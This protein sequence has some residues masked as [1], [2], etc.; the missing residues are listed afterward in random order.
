VF[1]VASQFAQP[2][3]AIG[4]AAGALSAGGAMV[5]VAGLWLPFGPGAR[6]RRAF[7]RA[8]RRFQ[9]GAWQEALV[10]VREQQQN[11]RLPLAWAGRLRNL[12]GECLRL[13]GEQAI[14]EQRFEEG[15]EHWLGSARLLGLEEGEA[16]SRVLEAMLDN[17][18]RL[19][20]GNAAADIEAAIQLAERV[21]ALQ[22][23]CAEAAFWQGLCFVR[24]ER[25]DLALQALRAAHDT[26][27]DG[28]FDPAFYLGTFL[29]R[30]GS[31]REAV[32]YLSEANRLAP[33]APVA[34]WQLGAAILAANG[35]SQVAARALQKARERLSALRKNENS[36]KR[37]WLDS[38]PEGKSYVR[39]LSLKYT[40]ACPLLGNHV[41]IMLREVQLS[42]GQAY[43]RHG[44]FPEAVQQYTSVLQES[45]PTVPV[46]R[47]LGQA[48]ARLER[49]EEAY[50]HLRAAY[51]REGT[52]N[53][54]TAG[55]LALC[56]AKG[57]PTAAEDRVKNVQWAL[58][59]ISQFEVRDDGEWAEL[60]NAIHAEA[61]GLDLP[62]AADDQVRLCEALASVAA[63]DCAAAAAYEH[64]AATFP[65]RVRAEYAWLHCRAVQ[66]QRCGGAHELDLFARTFQDEAPARAF[67]AERHWDFEDMEYAYLE[68]SAARRPGSFPE[69]IAPEYPARGETLLLGRS[70]RLE[71]TADNAGAL[72]SAEVLLLLAP[73]SAAA[74]DRLAQLHFRQG[75]LERSLAL[76]ADWH[77]LEADK[78]LPLIRLAVVEHARGNR[79]G[80]T[81]AIE[82]ALERAQ[83]KARA[84]A[85]FLGAR[86]GLADLLRDQT[87]EPNAA[88]TQGQKV[89]HW[90]SVCLE[91]DPEHKDAL[92]C[93]A[94]C[95]ALRGDR[96]NLADL[97]QRL[98]QSGNTDA[99]FQFMAACSHLAA[100]ATTNAVEAS[101]H[102]ESLDAT[103]APETAYL[104]GLSHARAGE[105]AAAAN[106]FAKVAQVVNSPSRQHAQARLGLMRFGQGDYETAI[107]C[108]QTVD[109]ARRAAWGLEEPLR[110]TVFLS[111]LQAFQANEPGRAAQRLREAGRLGY[112]DQSLGGLLMLAL[113][114][115]GQRLLR[116]SNKLSEA[117]GD[118]LEAAA[119]LF[120]QALNAGS[121]QPETAYLLALA[122][123]RQGKW[124]EARSAFRKI[125]QP[126]PNVHLQ[127]GILSLREGQLAQAEQELSAA[128]DLE[129]QSYALGWNLLRTRLSLGQTDG[130]VPL[131]T[132]L[133]E[134]AAN[135]HDQRLFKQLQ[136]LMPGA[137]ADSQAASI[138]AE[139]NGV[140]EERLLDLL[141][142]LG[143][144]DL[145][146][147]LLQNWTAA[148]T[149]AQEA[150]FAA[151]L[152]KGKRL[153]ERCDWHGAEQLLSPLKE[154]EASP[155]MQRLLLNFLGCCCCLSQDFE[156][157]LWHFQA[158]LRLDKNDPCVQQNLALV[159]EW[160]GKHAEA[161]PSWNSY[162]ENLPRRASA[163]SLPVDYRDRLAFEG[164]SRLATLYADKEQWPAALEF[165]QRAHN[166]RP[167]DADTLEK[168]FHLYTQAGRT[169]EARRVLRKL[170]QARPGDAEVELFEIDLVKVRNLD[171]IDGMIANIEE[172]LKRNPNDARVE[173]RVNVMAVNILPAFERIFN[174]LADQLARVANQVRYLP[175][176]QIDWSAVREVSRDLR[177]E[178]QRLRRLCNRCAALIKDDEPRRRLAELCT[179]CERKMDQCRSLVGG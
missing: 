90:L 54:F 20:A 145:A 61:R 75:D 59:L 84:M 92:W 104:R 163:P 89:S 144:P 123:K 2:L 153:L 149:G 12:E 95:H 130:C 44:S 173:V 9:Q 175:K 3:L 10:L 46:L 81:R 17:V 7:R 139:M 67:F 30:H 176:Y 36:T 79:D 57:K 85:A 136:Q 25:N 32:R 37:V 45:P 120:E 39:R 73:R 114:R 55:Y 49:Y 41:S 162:F 35:D 14:Q 129:P 69:V 166:L 63:A 127:L 101:A 11:G 88:S 28:F 109:P 155:E 56:A 177:Q 26:A 150:R 134:L 142:S 98:Q 5:L 27:D 99:R 34:A 152:V 77:E 8:Q 87:G 51:D 74:R 164:F 110:A 172:V 58:G 118:A 119:R 124:R 115:E 24:Q 64:L 159:H 38:L 80:Y 29:L 179:R 105:Q 72:D 31:A 156:R 103:L 62:I 53:P 128:F 148:R 42:L 15:L 165:A 48:L 86:L 140:E 161:Q 122:R 113:M 131:L 135:V 158:A 160:L 16:R 174:Q 111:A 137:A 100:G 40:F 4:A 97:S 76:L 65:E 1:L 82:Q 71:Q 107:A 22:T 151:L 146:S 94:A 108:W 33:S 93:L 19:F 68:R 171:S 168:L 121:K 66:T 112:R 126:D 125:S 117:D 78:P 132:R 143:N 91:E 47:G 141:R 154:T 133:G 83:G 147:A 60:C 23:P 167:N 43:Y 157:G 116:Q 52:R 96:Q 50:N 138:L 13:A 102:A 21:L 169:D 106:E 170:R 18:R 70:R 178:F 6:R